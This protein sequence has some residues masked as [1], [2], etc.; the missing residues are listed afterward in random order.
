MYSTFNTNI[1]ET[2][3]IFSKNVYTKYICR[4]NLVVECHASDLTAR[5][6]F[7]LPAPKKINIAKLCLFFIQVLNCGN[8]K[9]RCR[10]LS[11]SGASQCEGKIGP[12]DQFSDAGW[13]FGT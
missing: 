8:R 6:R 10:A 2:L 4:Y 1:P 13:A 12:V 3:V 9:G 5:V 7:P 11:W